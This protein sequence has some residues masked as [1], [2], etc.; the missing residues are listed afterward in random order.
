MSRLAEV[1][2]FVRARAL[3]DVFVIVLT[4][5]G[6]AHDLQRAEQAG[7]DLY[8]TRPFDPDELLAKAREVFN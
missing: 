3:P 7:A 8:L 5:S 1:R 4:D 2:E 6:Q